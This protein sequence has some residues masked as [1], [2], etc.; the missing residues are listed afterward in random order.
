MF[1]N[2]YGYGVYKRNQ[3]N[4]GNPYQVKM[5]S[6]MHTKSEEDYEEAACETDSFD[7]ELLISQDIVHKAKEEAVLIRHEARREAERIMSEAREKAQQEADELLQKAKEEGY[8]NGELLAQQNYNDLIEEAQA[9]KERCKSEY[10]DTLASLEQDMV[11]LVLNIAAKVIGDE[12]RNNRETILGIVRETVGACSNRA[13][14]LLRVSPEDYE[15]VVENEEK[16][17]SMIKDLDE[18]E[19]K[20]DGTLANGSCIVDTGYGAV[21]GSADIRLELVR[22]AFLEV[23]QNVK[24]D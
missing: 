8:R 4:I 23:L 6:P 2:S 12:I 18:L 1:S 17:R 20:K 15:I 7:Q 5:P 24:S 14:V 9:F 16:L 22:Q 10:E 3:V 21:D 19:I 11:T 13:H